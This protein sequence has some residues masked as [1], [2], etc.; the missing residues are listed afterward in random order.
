MFRLAELDANIDLRA[1][2]LW[3][4]EELE[5]NFRDECK[6]G[7]AYV[8]DIR[9]HK[10]RWIAE[11]YMYGRTMDV[12]SIAAQVVSALASP[13]TIRRIAITP[14]YGE[15]DVIRDSILDRNAKA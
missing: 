14:R 13:E 4:I 1:R 5:K 10:L 15:D 7:V 11:G 12:A 9:A 3:K 6:K 2:S 8:A